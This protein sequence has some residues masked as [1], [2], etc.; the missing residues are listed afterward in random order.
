MNLRIKDIA[1]R[2]CVATV[3]VTHKID[4]AYEVA[5]RMV[6]LHHGRIVVNGTPEEVRTT[7]D[8]LV[9]QFVDG[10]AEGPISMSSKARG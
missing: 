5:D 1:S 9:R 8:P 4:S 7:T 3:V 10:K 6:M 2:R